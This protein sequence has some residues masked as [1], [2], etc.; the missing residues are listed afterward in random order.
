L[1]QYE[2]LGW[3]FFSLFNLFFFLGMWM[4]DLIIEP[5]VS[6]VINIINKDYNAAINN[7]SIPIFIFLI[8]YLISLLFSYA[9][10]L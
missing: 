7:I 6:S 9:D 1:L 5:I 10:T 3:F 8:L 4:L 2:K